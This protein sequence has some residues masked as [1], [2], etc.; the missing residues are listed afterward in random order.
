[1]DYIMSSHCEGFVLIWQNQTRKI[2]IF[3]YSIKCKLW[4]SFPS[5]LSPTSFYVV[6]FSP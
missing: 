2:H 4:I 3:L 5:K 1:M 6:F